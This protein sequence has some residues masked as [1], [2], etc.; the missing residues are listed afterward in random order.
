MPSQSLT[1]ILGKTPTRGKMKCID[2]RTPTPEVLEK[3]PILEVLEGRGTTLDPL[4][5]G[6]ADLM[7]KAII[8]LFFV[9]QIFFVTS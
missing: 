5:Q 1:P 2:V 7:S 6:L 4:H 8:F 3:I 9:L